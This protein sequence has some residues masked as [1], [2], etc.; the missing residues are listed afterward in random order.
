MILKTFAI[1]DKA[2]DTFGATFQQPTIDAGLR[3]FREVVLFGDENNR[4]KRNPEDY[5]LYYVGEYNDD[6]GELVNADNIMLSSAVEIITELKN[7]E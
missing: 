2:L 1:K 6:S 4:Y 3:M 5:S 7:Q